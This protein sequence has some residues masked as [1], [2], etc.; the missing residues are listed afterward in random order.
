MAIYP[1]FPCSKPFKGRFFTLT[2]LVGS[3]MML[4]LYCG[5]AQQVAIVGFS[6]N[7]D[8]Q[9]NRFTFVA[10]QNI[11]NGTQIFFTDATL[12]GGSFGTE[13]RVQYT[14]QGLSTG[15]VVMIAESTTP[16][17]LLVTCTSG[18]NC[19][20]ATLLDGPFSLT[21]EDVL[22]AYTTS[23]SLAIFSAFPGPK[24]AFTAGDVT[25]VTSSAIILSQGNKNVLE[26]SPDL[27]SGKVTKAR[28]HR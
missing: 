25:S 8:V 6:T 17:T 4:S 18:S 20:T 28:F 14:S 2:F 9:T 23:G 19:G 3:L 21:P 13:S 7:T 12:S 10:L 22:Y 5:F 16:N 11:P 27:R 24:A 26:F 15:D 1:P